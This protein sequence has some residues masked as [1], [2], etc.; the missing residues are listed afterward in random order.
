MKEFLIAMV[1]IVLLEVLVEVILVDGNTKKY[2][3]ATMSL[4]VLLVFLCQISAFLKKGFT[5]PNFDESSEQTI[6]VDTQTLN[7]FNM[8]EYENA[9]K[10]ITAGLKNDGIEGVGITFSYIYNIEGA[11]LI[12]NIFVDTG[13]LVIKENAKNININEKIIWYCMQ[14][15]NIEKKRIIINGE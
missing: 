14:N 6:S 7:K 15:T 1:A 11:L 8:L 5:M 3:M 10:N 12:E 9:I 4:V 13:N 2:I